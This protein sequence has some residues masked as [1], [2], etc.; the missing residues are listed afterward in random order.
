ME[1]TVVWYIRMSLTYFFVAALLGLIMII[2]PESIFYYRN[3]H[4][5][6]N[7]LGW[8]SMMIYGVGY[9]VLPKFSGKLIYSPALMKI[10]FWFANLGLIGMAVGWTMIGRDIAAEGARGLLL[11]SAVTV[12]A[13]IG[14]FAF[15]IG[16]TVTPIKKPAG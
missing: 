9:H 12:L 10:Q 5:H 8:M 3:V 4:V 1:K 7:L 13:G 14:M 11:V 16:K 6:F 2:H 15:N